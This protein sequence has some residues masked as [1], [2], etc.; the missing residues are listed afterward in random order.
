[1]KLERFRVTNYRSVK[2]SG[3]IDVAQQTA[4]VGRNE[5]GKSNLLR[6][7]RSLKPPQGPEALSI[8]RD[9]PAERHVHWRRC[10]SQVSIF[11]SNQDSTAPLTATTPYRPSVASQRSGASPRMAAWRFWWCR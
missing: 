6:A 3:W 11:F 7:L 10:A 8:A 9:F 4:L 5:S 2:D 1:M